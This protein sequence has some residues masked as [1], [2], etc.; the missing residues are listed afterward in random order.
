M[1]DRASEFTVLK[2]TEDLRH[3]VQVNLK[4]LLLN[5]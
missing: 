3:F 1:D 5:V 4:S 2:F